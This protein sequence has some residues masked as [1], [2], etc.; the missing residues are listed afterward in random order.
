LSW[1]ARTVVSV[2]LFSLAGGALIAYVVVEL[3]P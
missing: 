2:L 3:A 1:W